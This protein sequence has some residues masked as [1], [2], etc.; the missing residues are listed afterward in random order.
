MD[1]NTLVSALL[2][3]V[4]GGGLGSLV[5][6]MSLRDTRAQ[7]LRDRQWLDAEIVADARQLLKDIDP[8]RR[9]INL[10]RTPGVEDQRW[11]ALNQRSEDIYKQLVRLAAGHPSAT[12]QSRAEELSSAILRAAYQSQWHVKDLLADRWDSAQLGKAQE[13]QEK[14]ES[15]AAELERAVKTARSRSKDRKRD[16]QD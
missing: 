2:G 12:V 5:A 4:L 13:E 6:Y 10:D 11:A 9:G 1:W 16:G 3:G 8:Q 15:V 14:A 7:G